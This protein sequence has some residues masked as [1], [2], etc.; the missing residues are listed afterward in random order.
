[1]GARHIGF[2]PGFIDEDEPGG[3]DRRLTRLPTLTPEG[4]VRSILFGRA[5]A[6]F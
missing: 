5:Q 2:G 4:D 6:F 1:M 3:I